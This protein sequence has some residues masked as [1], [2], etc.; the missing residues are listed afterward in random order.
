V[1]SAAVRHQAPRMSPVLWVFSR[2]SRATRS[3]SSGFRHPQGIG[4]ARL[5]YKVFQILEPYVDYSV[6]TSKTLCRVRG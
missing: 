3:A 6:S 1:A 4:P 2:F 5:I